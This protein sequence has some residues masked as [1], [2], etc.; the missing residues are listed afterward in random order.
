MGDVQHIP[1][2]ITCQYDMLCMMCR[3]VS[4]LKNHIVNPVVTPSAVSGTPSGILAASL[5]GPDYKYSAVWTPVNMQLG[6]HSVKTIATAY[7]FY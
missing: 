1:L 3:Y 2:S 5:V 6:E 4:S 7:Y